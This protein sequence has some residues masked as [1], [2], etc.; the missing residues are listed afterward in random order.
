MEPGTSAVEASFWD[1]NDEFATCMPMYRTGFEECYSQRTMESIGAHQR[2]IDFGRTLWSIGALLIVMA[3]IKW[4]GKS[5]L[6]KP[7]EKKL[8]LKLFVIC[9]IFEIVVLGIWMYLRFTQA[10][11]E[12][13]PVQ[14]ALNVFLLP[15]M[16]IAFTLVGL[17]F[18]YRGKRS[19][20]VIFCFVVT[21][22][23]PILFLSLFM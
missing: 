15:A 11:W 16:A 2:I 7:S 13:F 4:R 17:Y 20:L 23:A 6:S 1:D 19:V 10:F 22:L 8:F 18:G 5:I 9:S 3:F 14:N 12:R 21:V